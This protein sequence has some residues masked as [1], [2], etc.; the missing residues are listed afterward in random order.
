MNLWISDSLFGLSSPTGGQGALLSTTLWQR[1]DEWDKWLFLKLNR[2]W[3]N[4]VFDLILPYFRDAVFWAPFYIFLLS[5][6]LLNYGKKGWWWTIGFLCTVA[7]AD[8]VSSRVVKEGFERLRPCQDPL[9]FQQVRL[10]LKHCSG[11]YS[12]T[13]SHAA[14]HFGIASYI[15]ITLYPAFGRWIF[16]I[17]LWALFVSYAQVY[18]G[19]HYP[20]DVLGG[21]GIGTLAGLLT[22]R[23]YKYKVGSFT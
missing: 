8:L 4:P 12:F 14:N 7:I 23:V 15:S 20:L 10:L 16:I 22:T 18:V 2:D 3:T 21:A 13:S 1:L 5:F 6:I 9:F 17:Y 11:S 19:V